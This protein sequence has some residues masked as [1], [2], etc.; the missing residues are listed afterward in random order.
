MRSLLLALLLFPS[1]GMGQEPSLEMLEKSM[2][3]LI[4]SVEHAIDRFNLFTG[5]RPVPLVVEDLNKEAADIG[6]T[7]KRIQTTVESRLRGGRIYLD[8]YADDIY[9]YVQVTVVGRAFSVL[10]QFNK[11]MTDPLSGEIGRPITWQDSGVGTTGGD[12]GYILQ[13]VGELADRFV[14]EYLRVNEK[15]C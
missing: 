3:E 10:F 8:G 7:Q 14:T 11:A 13:G 4:L 9:L 1:I 6:L 2:E 12:A 15:S 5:C